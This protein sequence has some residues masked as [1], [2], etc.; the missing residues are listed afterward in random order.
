[1]V[2]CMME[3]YDLN[4]RPVEKQFIDENIVGGGE[5]HPL[6]IYIKAMVKFTLFFI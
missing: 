4:D 1:M 6:R 5:R 3:W 2:M